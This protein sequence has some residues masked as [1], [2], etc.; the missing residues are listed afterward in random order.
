MK[1]NEHEVKEFRRTMLELGVD[2]VVVI[3]PVV[4]TIEQGIQF[5]PTDPKHWLYDP[6]EF[7]RGVLK[8]RELPDNMCPAIYYS[9]AIHVNGNVVPCCRDPRGTEVMGNIFT[10]SLDEIWNGRPFQDLRER[11]HRDQSS[12]E[13]CRLCSSYPAGRLN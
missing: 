7:T 1:H 4:R 11:I 10:Q 6:A 2:R 9:M 5:L 13:I 3:D 12:V 8:P